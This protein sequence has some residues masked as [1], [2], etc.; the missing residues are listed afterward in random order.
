MNAIHVANPS[1]CLQ[2]GSNDRH[3]NT[4]GQV[5]VYFANRGWVHAEGSAAR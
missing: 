2:A 1:P 4:C 5:V 3:C